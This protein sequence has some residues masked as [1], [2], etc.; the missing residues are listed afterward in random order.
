MVMLS[1]PVSLCCP[2][3]SIISAFQKFPLHRFVDFWE[4]EFCPEWNKFLLACF[5]TQLTFF[6]ERQPCVDVPDLATKKNL[7]HANSVRS[8]PPWHAM[9]ESKKH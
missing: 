8:M 3:T 7:L 4:L 9:Q 5:P 6:Y 2:E 1:Q